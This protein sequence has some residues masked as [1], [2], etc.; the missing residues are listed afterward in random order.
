VLT[1]R[2]PIVEMFVHELFGES[3][4]TGGGTSTTGFAM[5]FGGGIDAGVRKGI[6]LR[7]VQA[8]WMSLRFNGVTD[9]KNTRVSTGIVLQ[10]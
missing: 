5:M 6:G 3:R 7:I 2:L 4:V 10:F 1:A 8:D 9:N